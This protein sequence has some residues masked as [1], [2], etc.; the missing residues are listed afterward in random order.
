MIPSY[1]NHSLLSSLWALHHCY[2]K[3][4]QLLY[5]QHSVLNFCH[6]GMAYMAII[7]SMLLI[8]NYKEH[9][10]QNKEIYNQHGN[11]YVLSLP[12]CRSKSLFP[13]RSNPPRPLPPLEGRPSPLPRPRFPNRPRAL[14][15]LLKF[16][17][18]PSGL[19]L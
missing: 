19:S 8:H 3:T 13:P 6:H 2:S 11:P 17:P 18:P 12:L 15:G 4:K 14:S 10:C 5:L 7:N 16:P 1:E 9:K